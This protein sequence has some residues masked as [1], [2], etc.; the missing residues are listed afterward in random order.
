MLAA[1]AVLT[2]AVLPF[3]AV[4]TRCS[5]RLGDYSNDNFED[6]RV[7]VPLAKFKATIEE[8]EDDLVDT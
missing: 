7:D 2:T 5:C 4:F 3:V 1:F 6:D 8:I